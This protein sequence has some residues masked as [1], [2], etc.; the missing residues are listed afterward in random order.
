MY[1]QMQKENKI[2]I[3]LDMLLLKMVE[4]EEEVLVILISLAIFQIYL[5]IFLVKVLVVEEGQEDR[6]IE[7]L[8]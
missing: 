7:V 3:I 4:V 6:T 2:M 5:K 1:S 8:I